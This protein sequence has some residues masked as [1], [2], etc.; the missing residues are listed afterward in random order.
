[1]FRIEIL[2]G[3]VASLE[4]LPRDVQRVFAAHITAIAEDPHGTGWAIDAA[5]D[6][7]DRVYDIPEGWIRYATKPDNPDDPAILITD[8]DWI[9]L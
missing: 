4:A 3:A 9:A 2:K 7:Y 6:V 8:L 1:M 5:A